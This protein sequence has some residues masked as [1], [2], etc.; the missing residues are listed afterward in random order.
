M[1]RKNPPVAEPPLCTGKKS[2]EPR[3]G[4][5]VM[6]TPRGTA[7]RT[8]LLDKA[9]PPQAEALLAGAVRLSAKVD[10]VGATLRIA[11]GTA[12]LKKV[13]AASI[14]L[15]RFESSNGSLQLVP[16]SSFDAAT[17]DGG[18][19]WGGLTQRTRRRLGAAAKRRCGQVA[20]ARDGAEGQPQDPVHRREDGHRL[21]LDF[22]LHQRQA[23]ILA[24]P[25]HDRA[26]E[27]Q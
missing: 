12:V 17:L 10:P 8:T 13:P 24:H 18:D 21:G 3:G 15:F 4:V 22:R 23:Q 6:C 20:E 2:K 19:P 9:A 25:R 11:I 16:H 5:E 26:G 27:Q 14:R 1:A 7:R